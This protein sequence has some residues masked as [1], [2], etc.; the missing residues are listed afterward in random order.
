MPQLVNKDE[1]VEEREH[2]EKN[3]NDF[4]NVHTINGQRPRPCIEYNQQLPAGNG[5]ITTSN[6]RFMP[7]E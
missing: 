1:Q 7:S 2:F 3:K 5:G 4:Y 6:A